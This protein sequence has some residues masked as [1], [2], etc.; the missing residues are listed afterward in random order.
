MAKFGSFFDEIR[1]ALK[2]GVTPW[3]ITLARVSIALVF[4]YSFIS[5]YL[6][7]NIHFLI[8]SFISLGLFLSFEYSVIYMKK[9]EEFLHEGAIKTQKKE[10]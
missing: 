6:D 8:L 7:F 3:L 10:D 5:M 2:P 1:E 4:I 9:N